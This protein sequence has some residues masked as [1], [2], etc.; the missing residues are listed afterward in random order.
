MEETKRPS[1]LEGYM[2]ASKETKYFYLFVFPW[3][4]GFLAFS[5]Y[6]ILTSLY[7]SFTDYNVVNPAKFVGLKNYKD[8]ISDELF[9][10]SVKATLYYALV[11][12]PVGLFLSLVFA[13]LLNMK[14]PGKRFFRVAMYLP[15][16]ISGAAM[17]LLWVWIFNPQIGLA[18]YALSLVGIKGPLWLLDEH[19]AMPS[20]IIMS[21]WS[22]GGGMVI[23]LAAL[24]GVP[25]SLREAATLDGANFWRRFWSITMPI[26]SPVFLFQ[27]IMSIIGSFQV[28]TQS[29]IMTH[30]GPHYATLFYVYYLYQ[31]AFVNFNLGYASAMAWLL[32][33]VIM[34]LTYV[35][36]RTSNRFI[37]YEGGR[38]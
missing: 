38:K 31:N 37:Y 10:K 16:M 2:N 23:F 14:V 22:V 30:G 27:L 15:S 13:L 12:V 6:P 20:L 3:I 4:V 19:W 9:W 33:I 25:A 34:L 26:I 7:Y 32:L 35:I 18:N 17:S 21:F 36:M 24:Q 28:F 8:M 1:I 29:F 5:L 11:S